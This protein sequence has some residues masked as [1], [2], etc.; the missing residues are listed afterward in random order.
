MIYAKIVVP[1]S[2]ANKYPKAG[3]PGINTKDIPQRT[4]ITLD[5]KSVFLI[6]N[7]S[8]NKPPHKFPSI[9]KKANIEPILA[10]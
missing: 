4:T 9:E 1:N 7:L 8:K 3:I 2:I 10:T 6:P 5:N